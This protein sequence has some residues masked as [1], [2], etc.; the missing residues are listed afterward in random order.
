MKL[1]AS[2]ILEVTKGKG[3]NLASVN[4]VTSVSIDSRKITFDALFV[5]ICGVTHDGHDY[6]AKAFQSGAI[7]G[8]I[9]EKEFQKRDDLKDLPLILVQNTDQ[10]LL[11][12]AALWRHQVVTPAIGITGSCGKSTTKEIVR[13]VLSQEKKVLATQGNFNNHYGLPIT[14]FQLDQSHEVIVCEMGANHQG[15]I[16]RLSEALDPSI[17]IITNIGA[18][19]LEGFGSL[20][21]VYRAKLELADYLATVNGTIVV[22]G[23]D[24]RLVKE[25]QT[26]AIRVITVGH[27]ASCDYVITNQQYHNNVFKVEL[28]QKVSFEL[29]SSARFDVM[30][31]ATAFAACRLSGMSETAIASAISSFRLSLDRFQLKIIDDVVFVYDAYNANPLSFSEA[32]ESFCALPVRGKRFIVCADMLELGRESQKWHADLGNQMSQFEIHGL[33]TVGK[34]S[35]Y[36]AEAFKQ[37]NKTSQVTSCQTNG[38]IVEVL[39][40]FIQPG[41]AV[42]LKGSR[43]MKLEQVIAG[44]SEKTQ[45]IEK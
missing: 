3:V 43:G 21:G 33:L 28:N 34:M 19:H 15:E 36:V 23:D 24:I 20:E 39:K 38:E 1:A 6:V 16:K 17:G 31:A 10:A 41:D 18:A 22:N 25:A 8:V 7:L 30:N 40:S 9:C 37:K 11:D 29:H 44:F 14:L 5:A 12:I 42:L 13:H 35:R 32:L 2:A 26:R 45:K 4:L 27:Q